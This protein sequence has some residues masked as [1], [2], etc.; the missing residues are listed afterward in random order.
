MPWAPKANYAIGR[1]Q[2]MFKDPRTV[3]ALS[4]E[5][6]TNHASTHDLGSRSE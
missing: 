3:I 2:C 4:F 6:Q 5:C 1:C